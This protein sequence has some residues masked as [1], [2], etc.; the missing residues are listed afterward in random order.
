[1]PVSY[2]EDKK[3]VV[4]VPGSNTVGLESKLLVFASLT[5]PFLG[6]CV[7][8]RQGERKHTYRGDLKVTREISDF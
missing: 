4:S 7:G 3:R 5:P 8:V 6:V 1:M 2:V